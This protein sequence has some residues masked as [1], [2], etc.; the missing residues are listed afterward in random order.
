M[1][2]DPAPFSQSHIS[3]AV[4]GERCA[5]ISAERSKIYDLAVLPPNCTDFDY[6]EYRIDF[7]VL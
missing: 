2:N 4:D 7:A 6:T 3:P 1:E 5:L